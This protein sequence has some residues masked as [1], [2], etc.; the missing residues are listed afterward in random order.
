V[1]DIVDDEAD[2]D[3]GEDFFGPSPVSD[4]GSDRAC[5]FGLLAEFGCDDEDEDDDVDVGHTSSS[6]CSSSS[7]S[8]SNS[9]PPTPSDIAFGTSI[10]NAFFCCCLVLPSEFIIIICC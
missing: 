4:N 7:S 5:S 1:E 9:L 3:V 2:E 10:L 6:S 8:T